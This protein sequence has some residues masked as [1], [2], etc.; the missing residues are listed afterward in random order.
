MKVELSAGNEYGLSVR[1]RPAE[2]K[3]LQSWIAIWTKPRAEK[4]VARFLEGRDVEV[5]LPLINSRRQWSD[6]VRVVALPLFPGYLFGRAAIGTWPSLLRT[7]GVLTV[8]KHGVQPAWIRDQQMDDL[9]AAVERIGK[10]GIEPD[11]EN[12]YFDD[13]DCVR[14]VEGPMAGLVGRVLE[15][16]G[17]RR[18]LIGIEQ[19]GRAISVSIKAA[20]VVR[21]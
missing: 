5:W 8:V 4:A 3:T 7:P 21:I 19:I 16:R 17:G 18:L 13:G 20:A 9:R 12:Q 6:R 11:V 15:H 14:V 10:F 2:C 1:A